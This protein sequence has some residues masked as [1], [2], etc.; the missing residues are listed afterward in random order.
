MMH[1]KKAMVVSSCVAALVASGDALAVCKD[2]KNA[3]YYAAAFDGKPMAW[4]GKSFNMN[5]P[6]TV[7]HKSLPFGT[8]V[9]ACTKKAC[10]DAVVRDRGPYVAGCQWDFSL[11]GAKRL[12]FKEAGTA[13]VRVV[14]KK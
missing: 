10:I 6:T 5:D 2:G 1:L 9:H 4:G 8:K 11:A 14:V 7:A 3:S 13:Y 12:G